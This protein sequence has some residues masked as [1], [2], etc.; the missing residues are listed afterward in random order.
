MLTSV[1]LIKRG[2]LISFCLFLRGEG[3]GGV[4]CSSAPVIYLIGNSSSSSWCES[5]SELC[6]ILFSIVHCDA[7]S[8]RRYNAARDVTYRAPR[9]D[10]RPDQMTTLTRDVT[11]HV[12]Q[13]RSADSSIGTPPR[14]FTLYRSIAEHPMYH[15]VDQ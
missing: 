5:S 10:L 9:D 6:S 7:T 4:G 12:T 15:T 14:F 11:G 1:E 3:W 2:S 13:Y 8:T